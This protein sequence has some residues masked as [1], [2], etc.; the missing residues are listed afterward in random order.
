LHCFAEL[1]AQGTRERSFSVDPG[2]KVLSA[3]RLAL[4]VPRENCTFGYA[5]Y[6][7]ANASASAGEDALTLIEV[8][9]KMFDAEIVKMVEEK[10]RLERT[11]IASHSRVSEELTSLKKVSKLVC[12]L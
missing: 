4:S 12:V 8:F 2:T 11:I 10:N 3:K 6:V 1:P 9:R 7:E 5:S